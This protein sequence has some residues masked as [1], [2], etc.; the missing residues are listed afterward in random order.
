[1]LIAYEEPDLI[2][3]TEV[4]PKAQIAPLLTHLIT[5]P[6]FTPLF[7]FDSNLPNLWTSNT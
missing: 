2:L 3:V 6:G 7:N 1:M 4:I 5:I